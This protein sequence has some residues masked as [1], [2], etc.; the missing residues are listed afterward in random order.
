MEDYFELGYIK[1]TT[2]LKGMMWVSADAD[3]PEAYL[4]LEVVFTEE[5]GQAVPHFPDHWSLEPNGQFRL[6]LEDILTEEAA[7][8]MVGK[9]LFL[10]LELLPPL[11][12][13][14][15][16]YHEIMGWEVH[17]ATGEVIG[18]VK[19]IYDRGP[20][21]LLLIDRGK[22][23]EIYLPLPDELLLEVNRELKFLKIQIPEGLL[24]VYDSSSKDEER[25]L[26]E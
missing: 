6:H 24:E 2:G 14:R 19:D 13:K 17:D 1:R 8:R 9:K 23:S 20:Q 26:D 21:E 7:Q 18:K 3:Q 22:L 16:Y 12:G 10:P 15:F 11:T 25:D 4:D 5:G